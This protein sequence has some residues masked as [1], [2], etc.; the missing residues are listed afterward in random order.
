MSQS[1]DVND[2][3]AMRPAQMIEIEEVVD[4]DEIETVES[5]SHASRLELD[6][7]ESHASRTD[8][9]FNLRVRQPKSRNEMQ[10][11]P[12]APESLDEPEPQVLYLGIHGWMHLKEGSTLTSGTFR[13]ASSDDLESTTKDDEEEG[14]DTSPP[15]KDQPILISNSSKSD[16]S[17]DMTAAKKA[18]LRKVVVRALPKKSSKKLQSK[19]DR[20]RATKRPK[21][22]IKAGTSESGSRKRIKFEKFVPFQSRVACKT[23]RE[24]APFKPVETKRKTPTKSSPTNGSG[25][26][27]SSYKSS[28]TVAMELEKQKANGG[29]LG[30]Y[31]IT[32]I[33]FDDVLLGR[34][35][36][37]VTYEGNIRYRKVI[38]MHRDRYIAAGRI[39]KGQIAKKVIETVWSRGGRFLESKNND[40]RV[41]R[42]AELPRLLEKATQALR[43]KH[44]WKE[45]PEDRSGRV[46]R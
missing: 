26:R 46:R 35:N 45:H 18:A 33:T 36:N 21:K 5:G 1:G 2:G 6:R 19:D 14:V 9:R 38:L 40:Q 8:H 30:D 15:S 42:E 32:D 7:S 23:A 27:I 44:A 31:N 22:A 28:R 11:D 37:L 10:H 24:P 3:V 17:G 16:D 13:E 39:E 43:E 20:P 25:P 29:K 12:S 34:G 41:W 4:T